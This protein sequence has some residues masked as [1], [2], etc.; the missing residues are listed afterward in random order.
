[1]NTTDS[2][3]YSKIQT[4]ITGILDLTSTSTQINV[5]LSSISTA[6]DTK[7]KK[8]RR[9]KAPAG[10]RIELLIPNLNFQA[11]YNNSAIKCPVTFL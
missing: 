2:T 7:E 8:S 4:N 1:M 9:K 10:L 6:D 3:H 11:K 5:K